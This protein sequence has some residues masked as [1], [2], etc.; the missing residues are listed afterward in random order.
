MTDNW[1]T[2]NC[3][4]IKFTMDP[5]IIIPSFPPD[6]FYLGLSSKSNFETKTGQNESDQLESQLHFNQDVPILR[7][8][9]SDSELKVQLQTFPL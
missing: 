5:K 3:G 2:D 9:E 4:H 1:L 7:E 8:R 6:I